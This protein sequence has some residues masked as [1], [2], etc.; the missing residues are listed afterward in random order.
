MKPTKTAQLVLDATEALRQGCNR[1]RF[2]VPYVYNP[3]DY[4]KAP[5]DL[6][7]TKYARSKKRVMFLG[8]NPGP[9]GMA[10]TGVPFGE[11]SIA[12]DWLKV[13]APVGRATHEHKKRPI[14]G[15]ACPRS[16]VSGSR[17]WG[18]FQEKFGTAKAFFQSHYVANY[19]PLVFLE[20]TGRN[21][22]PDKLAKAERD[23]LE[24]V[25]DAHL[26]ALVHALK[27]DFVVG[28]GKF[29]EARAHKALPNFAGTIATVL[30]PSP[31][32]PLANRGWAPQA[33]RQLRDIG[34]W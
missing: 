14:Q 9:F 11:V 16:E 34:I 17:L 29:A 30:H 24:K 22:T 32:S 7:V 5:H 8:M 18:L 12:K 33:E 2:D 19:C 1:L 28:V 27:P 20:E 21:K 15:F 31:A 3:L 26:A 4:A 10:Q 25:C 6:Y 13:E 23:A